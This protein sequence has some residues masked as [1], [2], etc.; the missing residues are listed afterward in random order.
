MYIKQ[1]INKD[2]KLDIEK[3]SYSNF[4]LIKYN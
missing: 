4:N 2:F 3:G 1:V